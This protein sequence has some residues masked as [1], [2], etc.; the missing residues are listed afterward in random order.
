MPDDPAFGPTV[1]ALHAHW[2]AG[3]GL[4]ILL[5]GVA[6][7]VILWHAPSRTYHATA[8][9]ALDEKQVGLLVGRLNSAWLARQAGVG[10]GVSVTALAR[11]GSPLVD[12]VGTAP[13]PREAVAGAN[14]VVTTLAGLLASEAEAR[15]R[16]TFATI[17]AERQRLEAERDRVLIR[18]GPEVV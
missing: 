2:R 3:A 18:L 15:R 4:V 11:K 12:V 13:T 10:A 7:G 17:V 5:G 6:S 1:R 9:V 8:V 16:D 14:G